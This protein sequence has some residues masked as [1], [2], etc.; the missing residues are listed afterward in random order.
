MP[1]ISGQEIISEGTEKSQNRL[2]IFASAAILAKSYNI[3]LGEMKFLGVELP[4]AVFD[5]ALLMLVLW[6]TY[7]FLVKW[8]TDLAA[9]RLWF[10]DSSIWSN[11]GT[12]MLLDRS[13]LSGGIELIKS[14]YLIDKK[15]DSIDGIDDD[16]LKLYQDFELNVKLYSHRLSKVGTKFQVLSL[17]GHFYLWIQNFAF[18]ILFAVIAIYL[19]C[20]YG[21]F[22]IPPQL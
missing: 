15:I 6:F 18:P 22:T 7:S 8:L 11:F 16:T 13:Y 10:V 20:K 12:K 4:S 2:L 19:L 14:L 3:P 1:K 21:S 5:V 17:F 9:F